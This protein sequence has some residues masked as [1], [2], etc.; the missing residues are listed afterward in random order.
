MRT[1]GRRPAW[2][3]GTVIACCKYGGMPLISL[4]TLVIGVVLGAVIGF[5][6][7]RNR[8]A[9][10]MADLAA[11]AS[12]ADER[13]RAAEQRT[14]L[15]DGQLAER[16]QALSAQ[17]LD[18]S[19]RRFL[20]MAE[21]RLSAANANAAGELDNRRAAVEGL[22]GPLKETLTRV[23]AQLRESDAQRAASHAALAEQM[24]I[25]RRSSDELKRQTQALV[26]ALRKPEARGRWGEMQLR[27][28]VELAGMSAR[29]D[30]DEQVTV[31][32]AEGQLRPDMVIHLAGGKQIVVDSKVSLAAYLE[33][34]E[35]ADDTV[36]E[37]RL[38]A[39]ARHLRDHVDKLA[40]K[41]Y[42]TA[43]SPAPEFAV[44]FI[45]GEAFL[46]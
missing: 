9:G 10:A 39:H 22:V 8:E 36:R 27:R 33:A 16:F 38:A 13:A 18:A 25:T 30:F 24:T 37:T 14:A 40:A 26:T 12:A 41:A 34:A 6:V 42:W 32:T 11:R 29:C 31:A 43:L 45:P 1:G 5:L 3:M 7:A 23:E 44:L 20:E 17:A 21:G 2:R 28:V 4:L 46:A 15:V 35:A 19:A